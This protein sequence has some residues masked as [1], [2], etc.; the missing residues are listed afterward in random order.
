MVPSEIHVP[1]GPGE[2]HVNLGP[3]EIH[4]SLGPG[5]VHVK[6]VPSEIY[7]PLGPGEIHANLGPG[8]SF[9]LSSDFSNL[10]EPGVRWS[11][12]VMP[13]S[14]YG[15]EG[16]GNTHLSCTSYKELIR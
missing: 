8:G 16:C 3:G 15:F 12:W 13:Y 4:A 2:I 1:L 5:E 14:V 10:V 11:V 9:V 6:L 7:V